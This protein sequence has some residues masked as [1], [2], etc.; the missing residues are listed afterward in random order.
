MKRFL[1]SALA[2]LVFLAAAAGV[3]GWL[4]SPASENGIYALCFAAM[5]FT[6]GC[7]LMS[8]RH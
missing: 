5:C 6:S 1:V 4:S 2:V 3:A 7:A 8:F